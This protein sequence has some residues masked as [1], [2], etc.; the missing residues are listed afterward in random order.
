MT[1]RTL[2]DHTGSFLSWHQALQS[3]IFL[4]SP[5]LGSVEET[6]QSPRGQVRQ[7]GPVRNKSSQLER[8][9]SHAARAEAGSPPRPHTPSGTRRVQ[10]PVPRPPCAGTRPTCPGATGRSSPPRTHLASDA[11]DERHL[12]GLAHLAV[13]GDPGDRAASGR[14][15]H[16]AAGG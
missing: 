15:S 10:F 9:E 13:P 1:P 11:R 2:T 5:L 14:V 3:T 16:V 4:P 6:P 7:S 8:A 12:P